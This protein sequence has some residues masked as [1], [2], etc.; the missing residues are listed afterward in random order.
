MKVIDEQWRTLRVIM[1]NDDL[2]DGGKKLVSCLMKNEQLLTQTGRN[3]REFWTSLCVRVLLSCELAVLRTFWGSS[4]SDD[5][6]TWEWD[7]DVATRS[8]VWRKFA[9]A[10]NDFG[11]ISLESMSFLLALPFL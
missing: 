8:Y 3:V 11:E 2:V 4:Y 9:C 6:P 1:H 5:L 7:W 10:W